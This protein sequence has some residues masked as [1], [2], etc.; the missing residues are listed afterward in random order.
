MPGPEA[1]PARELVGDAVGRGMP[2][3]AG[4]IEIAAVETGPE[5]RKR[6]KK[7]LGVA[8]WL[9]IGWIALVVGLAILAPVLPLDDPKESITAIARR[10]PLA[11]AGTAPGHLLGGDFN[12]RDMLSR[13]IWGGRVTLVVATLAVIIGFIFGGLLGLVGGYFRGKVDVVV[14]LLL[15]VFLAIPA[16]ILALALVTI[17]RT[18]PGT[19]GGGLDPEV[20]LILALGLRVDPGARAHHARQHVVVVAARVRARGARAGRQAPAH[21]HARGTAQRVAGDDVDRAARHRG[22]DRRRGH[23]RHP[24]RQRGDRHAHVGQHDRHRSH[25]TPAGAAHRVRTRADDLLH[26]ARA[27]HARRRRAQPLRRTGGRPVSDGVP[28]PLLEVTD[29]ATHFDTERGL[30][31]AVDGVSFT[32]ERGRTV[33]IVGESGSGKTVLSRSIMG[34][35]PKKNVVR[36]GSIKFEGVEIGAASP[37]QMRKY[38]GAH[39]GMVFQDPMTAL[40]PVMKIGNQITESIHTHL[41]VSRTFASELAVS[42]LESVRVPDPERRMD[43]YPHQLSGG[44]RQRVCIAV[45]LA[46][47]PQLLLADEPTTALDVTVQAQV[48]DVLEAQQRERFMAMVLVTHDLGV[49]AGRADEVIVM[50][51]GQVVEK[52]S[53]ATL[54][55]D[56]KMPYTEALLRSIPKIA[57]PSHTTPLG[58][59]RAPARPRPPPD[60]LPVRGAVPVR[61]GPLPRRAAA[62]AAGHD[63][64]ATSTGAGSRSAHPRARP[65]W[66][67]TSRPVAM[68][69][70]AVAMMEMQRRRGR[71]PGRRSGIDQC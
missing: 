17:L 57:E 36:H 70:S 16:V 47:G 14:S 23:P 18:Q 41:D 30:V 51:A 24:R 48:L 3:D 49:V 27:Q 58:H 33:G 52:A 68:E 8:A 6:R 15:D 66:P 65:R 31:H 60:R 39:M 5:V 35:L 22:G 40:N 71:R 45:A 20:A 12:G 43:E 64:R 37:K 54:F 50:Y 42:L 53:T 55:S 63:A 10:G 62:A 25:P 61:A 34:L 13:L 7:G 1:D 44:L 21:H 32:L 69:M 29:V 11:D 26:R 4:T 46:C 28:P 9:S 38:W 67:A 2:V 19:N 59:P 56:M